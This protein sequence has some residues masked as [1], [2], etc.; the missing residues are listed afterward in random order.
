MAGFLVVPIN[1]RGV[2]DYENDVSKVDNLTYFDFPNDEFDFLFR[3][4]IIN[5][6]NFDFDIMIDEHEEE[7]I[8]NQ[9]L[10]KAR[11]IVIPY[12]YNVPIFYQ[13][14]ELAIQRNTELCLEC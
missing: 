12:K 7:I 10:L 6:Y 11:E 8:Q 4:G 9:H 5:K 2:L 1:E 3:E 14:L 13:A